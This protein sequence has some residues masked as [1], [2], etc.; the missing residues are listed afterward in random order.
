MRVV[1][2]GSTQRDREIWPVATPWIHQVHAVLDPAN[3]VGNRSMFSPSSF[4]SFMQN[5]QWSV[6]T[7]CRSLVRSACHMASW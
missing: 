1:E 5:G 4:C 3:P 2:V 6:E 7:I